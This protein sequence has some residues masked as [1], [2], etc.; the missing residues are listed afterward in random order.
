MVPQSVAKNYCIQKERQIKQKYRPLYCSQSTN[1]K[2]LCVLINISIKVAVGTVE[3]VFLLNN[4][5]T[6][7]SKAV[8][9]LWIFLL[10]VCCVCLCHAV[11]SVSCSLVVICWEMADL[12][13]LLY[14]MFNCVFATFP[15]GVLGQ[16]G[17]QVRYLIVSISDFCLRA[18]CLGDVQTHS[19]VLPVQRPSE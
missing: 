15:Y 16:V 17:G 2:Q 8:L 6:E 12:L 14:V 3:Q 10:F 1:N 13:A 9:L 4:F 19:S 18:F 7:R 5:L 11:L